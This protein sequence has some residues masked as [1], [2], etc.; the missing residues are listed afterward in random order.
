MTRQVRVGPTRNRCHGLGGPAGRREPDAARVPARQRRE[1]LERD[2][3]VGPAL[4]RHER[5]DLVDDHVLDRL[6]VAGPAR[7]AEQER[8]ALGGRDQEVGRLVAELAAGVGRGV[9]GPHADAHR[10]CPRAR[11]AAGCPPAGSPG[12][13]RCRSPGSAA[14]RRRRTASPARASPRHV[15]G[16]AGRGSRGT[17]RGSCP[18]PSARPGARARPPRSAARP[19]LCAGSA[20][21][22]TSSANQLRTGPEEQWPFVSSPRV[23]V[24]CILAMMGH[25]GPIGSVNQDPDR[26]KGPGLAGQADTPHDSQALVEWKPVQD[27]EFSPP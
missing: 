13:A 20:H 19:A 25:P 16:R 14:A 26:K 24:M 4:G 10:A 15:P 17:R 27:A 9:P 18:S 22:E 12:S 6:P 1:P 7:L 11:A 2:G 5:V 23:S 3:Q 21:R 8:Q